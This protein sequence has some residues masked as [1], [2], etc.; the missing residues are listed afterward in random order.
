M[1][2]IRTVIYNELPL[3]RAETLPGRV[4]AC[5]CGSWDRRGGSFDLHMADQIATAIFI[6]EEESK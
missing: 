2:D 3:H 1:S 6:H 4:W 5:S